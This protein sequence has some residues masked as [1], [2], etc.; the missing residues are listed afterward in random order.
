MARQWTPAALLA[1]L[2]AALLCLMCAVTNAGS[3]RVLG[4]DSL[5]ATCREISRYTGGYIERAGVVSAA[6]AVE[7]R[8]AF[9]FV[10]YGL[11]LFNDYRMCPLCLSVASLMCAGSKYPIKALTTDT[12]AHNDLYALQALTGIAIE[13][14]EPVFPPQSCYKYLTKERKTLVPVLTK[15]HY[16]NQTEFEKVLTVDYDVFVTRGID[17]LFD[18]PM[19]ASYLAASPAFCQDERL[20][21]DGFAPISA[22]QARKAGTNHFNA[23]I[24]LARPSHQ[25]FRRLQKDKERLNRCVMGVEQPLL[26]EYFD[27]SK[28]GTWRF[29]AAFNCRT[30]RTS[31]CCEMDNMPM[32]VV[33]YSGKGIKPWY[34]NKET[35]QAIAGNGWRAGVL[36]MWRDVY[37]VMNE[38]APSLAHSHE[39][40][41]KAFGAAQ[42]AAERARANATAGVRSRKEEAM[43]YWVSKMQYMARKDKEGELADQQAVQGG[44]QTARTRSGDDGGEAR[45]DSGDGASHGKVAAAALTVAGDTTFDAR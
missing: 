7:W 38:T 13:F 5:S 15:L 1:A 12:V 23:G 28:R 22:T 10:V 3:D 40:G 4:G 34:N 45:D 18:I 25:M 26:N 36:H 44:V 33:H 9:L 41:L 8:R 37:T 32:H 11:S 43:D 31:S 24:V 19:G 6:P 35:R 20:G 29:S 27:Y 16:W 39:L 42:A 2:V 14:V 17:D 21:S 30:G